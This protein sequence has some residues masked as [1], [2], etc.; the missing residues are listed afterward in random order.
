ML[1]DPVAND[2]SLYWRDKGSTN[3]C[4]ID[5]E[6]VCNVASNDRRAKV[7]EGDSRTAVRRASDN[8]RGCNV[9]DATIRLTRAMRD[10]LR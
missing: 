6:A 3:A 5:V 2:V 7:R 4:L 1:G 9:D 8:S 10:A